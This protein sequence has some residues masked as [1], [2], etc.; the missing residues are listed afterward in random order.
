[1]TRRL[2]IAK[3]KCPV[4][5]KGQQPSERY[6]RYICTECV[7]RVTDKAGRAVTFSDAV[8]KNGKAL[9]G[10]VYGS[11]VDTGAQYRFKTCYIRGV[12][13][14]AAEAHFGGIVIQPDEI[15][16]K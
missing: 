16:S 11:Y 10:G 13:C 6:P 8:V 2:V 4:C 7:G 15:F 3:Q 1:M 14:I 12:R 5:G 9:M